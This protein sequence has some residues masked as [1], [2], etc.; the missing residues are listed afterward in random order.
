M[1]MGTNTSDIE[2]RPQRDGIRVMHLD[3]NA[4]ATYPL[5]NV[6]QMPMPYIN[7]L[8]SGYDPESLRGSHTR[9]QDTG[10]QELIPQLD[11]PVS[12]PSRTKEDC[13]RI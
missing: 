6:I 12:V 2:V 10:I 5:A 9:T 3:D 13:Q 11:R 1:D 4:Q 8:I 7:Q